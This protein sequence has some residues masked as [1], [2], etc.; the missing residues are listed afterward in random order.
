MAKSFFRNFTDQ[1]T[2][3][4]GKTTDVQIIRAVNHFEGEHS[5]LQKFRREFDK[6]TQAILTFDNASHR[7]F[8]FTRSLLDSF[9]TQ[10]RTLTQSCI[11][12][13]RIRNEHLKRLHAEINSNLDSL[14]HT[15]AKMRVRI[16]EQNRIQHDYDKTRKQYQAS[17][18]RDEQ[19]KVIRLK[20]ELAQLKST[21]YLINSELRNDLENFHFDVQ[22]YHVKIVLDLFDNHRKFYKNCRE[23][24]ADFIK[25][26]RENHLSNPEN[27]VSNFEKET[28]LTTGTSD[29]TIR[30]GT[31]VS[32][33]KQTSYKILHQARVI[34]DYY[35]EYDDEIDLVKDEY[36][37]VI[38]FH[39]EEDN[40]RDV[41]WEYAE[42]SN[43]L[44][45]LFPVN[46]VVRI[47]DNEGTNPNLTYE[48]KAESQEI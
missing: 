37:S 24:C 33:T 25:K 11:D 15:F 14:Q 13:G 2:G 44:I 8:D 9:Q 17:I 41:G 16:D 32:Q 45:G 31:S 35:A 4:G 21:L 12:I 34:H 28:R 18:K 19:A 30:L 48:S 43:G 7:F 46:F 29:E 27:D 5:K 47:Y 39:N 23:L 22:N 20:A 3:G 10:Q 36:I 26:L 42:K 1:M 6:Y 38:S 40:Q